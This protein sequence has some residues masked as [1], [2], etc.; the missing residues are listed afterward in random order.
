M[1]KFG[2]K[3]VFFWNVWAG[4]W[5]QHYHIWNQDTPICLISKFQEKKCLNL[6]PK[7][8]YFCNFCLGFRNNIVIFEI[9]TLEFVQLQNF[10]KKQKCLNLGP[11]ILYFGI[12]GLEF[13]KIYCIWNQHPWICLIAKFREKQKCL[14][15]GPN[16]PYLNV[17]GQE[18]EDTIVILEV[19]TPQFV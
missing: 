19:N 10:K 7:I 5:K 3:K 11:K 4:I 8:P 18:F 12:F 14:N 6:E 2:T 17:L 15:S 9:S 16:I 13:Q 1:P